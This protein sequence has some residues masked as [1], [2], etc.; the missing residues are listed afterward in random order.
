MTQCQ[1]GYILVSKKYLKK[2]QLD[3]IPYKYKIESSKSSNWSL[4]VCW[5]MALEKE[6]SASHFLKLRL[7]ELYFTFSIRHLLYLV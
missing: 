1:K 6:M 4:L 7:S 2:I 3:E 5:L